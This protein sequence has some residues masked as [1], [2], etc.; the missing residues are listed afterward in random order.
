MG[1]GGHISS[2]DS[3]TAGELHPYEEG[4]R[5]ELE[6]EVI[7]ETPYR[8]RCV[9]LI[10]DDSTEVGQVHLGVVHVFDVESPAV[11]PRESEILDAGFVPLSE[12]KQDFSRFET[13]SQISVQ[14]LFDD[15]N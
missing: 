6:E 1:V 3:D 5:R 4:M 7:I 15:A 14:A 9:G 10:N 11:R 2:I 13:W 8:E 12:L